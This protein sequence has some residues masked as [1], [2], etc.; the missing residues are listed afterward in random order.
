M[1]VDELPRA[2]RAVLPVRVVLLLADAR[3]G[4]HP[5]ELFDIVRVPP[6]EL[7]EILLDGERR[8]VKVGERSRG[9]E[10]VGRRGEGRMGA[11][12]GAQAGASGA[13]G[14]LCWRGRG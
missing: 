13:G 2:L 1:L 4:R 10:W 8:V 12:A 5:H 7:G 14:L 6:D 9:G 11:G 3:R